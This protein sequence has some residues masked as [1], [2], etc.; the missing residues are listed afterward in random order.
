R[1]LPHKGDFI[2]KPES[3]TLVEALSRDQRHLLQLTSQYNVAKEHASLVRKQIAEIDVASAELAKRAQI[4]RESM[5]ARLEREIEESKA[6]RVG[7]LAEVKQRRDIASR[8]EQLVKGGTASEIRT[9]EAMATH[10][11]ASTRCEMADARM[12]RLQIELAAAKDG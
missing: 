4:Y 6:E 5:V 1:D 11:A 9:A 10:E 3:V 12:K 8:M 2:E 7:C